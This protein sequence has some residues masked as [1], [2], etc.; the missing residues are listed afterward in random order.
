MILSL[1]LSLSLRCDDIEIIFP[2]F[3]DLVFQ[4]N[5]ESRDDTASNR[6]SEFNIMAGSLQKIHENYRAFRFG[7]S[8]STRREPRRGL[9]VHR[10]MSRP[11][12]MHSE[13]INYSSAVTLD[14]VERLDNVR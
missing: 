2:V 8:M 5:A 3:H 6:Y 13:C 14:R 11:R 7:L 1:I 9:H 10:Q 12:H 4:R